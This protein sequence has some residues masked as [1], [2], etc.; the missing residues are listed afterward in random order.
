MKRYE[1][2]PPN[3]LFLAIDSASVRVAVGMLLVPFPGGA[4]DRFEFG[5]ARFPAEFVDGFF[6]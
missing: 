1:V 3:A 6:G 4:D 2:G 5:V